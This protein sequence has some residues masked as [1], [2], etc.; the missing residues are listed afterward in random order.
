M[1]LGLFGSLIIGLIID[2]L[3]KISFLTFLA[4]FAEI[5]KSGTVVGGAIGVAVAWGLKSKPLAMFASVVTGAI[6]YSLSGG[7]PVGAY[8]AALVGARSLVLLLPGKRRLISCWF[9]W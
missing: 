7:G 2:Q 8:V 6:G 5:A 9:L 4:D 3:A 1:A